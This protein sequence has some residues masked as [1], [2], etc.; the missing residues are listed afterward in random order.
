MAVFIVLGLVAFLGSA[1]LAIDLGH[2]MNVR[3]ES[4]RV[5]DSA[6]LAAGSAFVDAAGP[7]VQPTARSRAIDIAWRNLIDQSSAVVTDADI[8]VGAGEEWVRV[9]VRNSGAAGNP[10]Q[11]Q[12][13]RMLGI[14][15]VDVVTT[16]VAQAFPATGATCI[17]PFALPDGFL[18]SGGD[19]ERF[20]APPDYYET[21]DPTVSPSPTATGYMESSRG[22]LRFL[23]APTGTTAGEPDP[24]WYYPIAAYTGLSTTFR[25]Q[26]AGCTD[27]SGVHHLGDNLRVEAVGYDAEMAEG[28]DLL[29]AQA[30]THAWSVAGS[31]VIDTAAADPNACVDGSPRLRAVALVDP[32]AVPGTGQLEVPVVNWAGIFIAGREGN[33]VRV[34]FTGFAGLDP[35]TGGSAGSSG[36]LAKTIRLV[37]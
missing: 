11:T 33:L 14:D 24:D 26:L 6:A 25:D 2:V 34:R 37:G 3:A 17:L 18:E 23:E 32:A 7:R 36:A 5:A 21:Y 9:T 31:C 12:F 4:Q 28:I 13:A 1:A 19:P 20:S 8:E 22:L 35:V 16:A 15:D 10:I 27:P 30:P 29:V